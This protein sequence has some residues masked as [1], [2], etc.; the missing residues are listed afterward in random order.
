MIPREDFDRYARAL[1]VNADLLQAAVA[2]AVDEC[3]GLWGDELYRELSRTYA[4][5]VAKFG[6][7]AAAAAVEFYAAMRE[8]SDPA[9]GYEPRQFDPGH[10]GLLASDVDTALRSASPGAA[11]AASAVQ[12]A[13]GYADATILG[14]SAAD[15]ARPR[16][17]LV[18]HAGACDWCR[19]IG[20][21]GF[22]FR[23]AATVGAERHPS[24]RCTPVADFSRD[25][26]LDGYDPRALYDEYSAK[27]P[28]WASRRSGSRGRR[29]SGKVTAAFVDGHRF[30]S[31]GDIQRFMDGAASMDELRARMATAN[32]AGAAMGFRPGSPYARSL[33]QTAQAR[34]RELAGK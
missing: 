5:L 12:R 28:D 15:P 34:A 9:R 31:I 29:G 10:G 1:N 22:V 8:G 24:C 19:M 11:L 30:E 23:S 4:A 21:R 26:G 20:S 2:Q 25:P 6:S 16:W 18:P 33:A 3:A 17:A 14:N 7:F 32:K 27:H 13:M